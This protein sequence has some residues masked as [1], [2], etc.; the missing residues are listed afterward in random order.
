LHQLRGRV[1]R[2]EHP[3]QVLLFADPKTADGRA[4]MQAIVST[5]D[6]FELAEY[7]LKLR[8]EGDVLGQRQSGL[9]ALRIASL[10]TDQDLLDLARAEARE[11]VATDPA[12][13]LPEH[14]PLAA[15]LRRRLGDAWK[16]VS[17]G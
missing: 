11:L 8:G 3:G 7:D 16:W 15:D 10:S 6:G 5:S 13:E 1:G 9:P 4:R 17:S 2:G 14:R 12:L